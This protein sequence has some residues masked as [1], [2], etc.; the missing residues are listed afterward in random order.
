MNFF[1]YQIFYFNVIEM[2]E[3]VSLISDAQGFNDFGFDPIPKKII[4]ND[5]IKNIIKEKP[6]VY[7]LFKKGKLIYVGSSKDL[8]SRLHIAHD[9]W[10][11]LNGKW[12]S[13]SYIETSNIN[14]AKD[15]EAIIQHILPIKNNKKV[16][17]L[18]TN[19]I[20]KQL[21]N[22]YKTIHM[23]KENKKEKND[24]DT[25]DIKTG[26]SSHKIDFNN[27]PDD[28]K[29]LFEEIEEKIM[30]KNEVSKV[31]AN[32]GFYIVY[33][34]GKK[35]IISVRPQH[36]NIKIWLNLKH[37]ELND[38]YGITRDVSNIGHWGNGDYEIAISPNE[39][40]KL[41]HVFELIDQIYDKFVGD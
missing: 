28:I 14:F 23:I 36:K 5:E 13:F 15:L 19:E 6:G 27:I 25:N 26:K 34:I 24:V 18:A 11:K 39:T 3:D 20:N 10:D 17:K 32:S 38:Q 35:N 21:I 31:M 40:E 29:K 9:G 2:G 4:E 37:G 30:S 16:E 12:D 33:K 41:K 8:Y 22:A 1:K 7:F